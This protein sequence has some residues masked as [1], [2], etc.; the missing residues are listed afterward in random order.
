VSE[1]LEKYEIRVYDKSGTQKAYASSTA[2][3]PVVISAKFVLARIGGC[4]TAT[5]E[6]IAP[7]LPGTVV[8]GYL[9]EMWAKPVGGSLA[10][11]WRGEVVECPNAGNTADVLEYRAVG[12]MSQLSRK[13]ILQYYSN[14]DTDN[15]VTSLIGAEFTDDTDVDSGTGEV[16]IGTPYALG[17]AEFEFISGAEALKLLAD[18]QKLVDYGVD[19][20][21]KVYFKDQ[22]I[23]TVVERYWVGKHL[24]SYETADNMDGL[25][26][27]LLL[28]S[29]KVVGGG[30]LTIGTTDATSITSYG[31]RMKL[32]QIPHLR[33]ASDIFRM[34]EGKVASTKDP[35]TEVEADVLL[36]FADFHFP[37]GAV[38]V[39]DI[40]GNAVTLPIQKTIYTLD[41]NGF[42]GRFELGDEPVMSVDEEMQAIMQEV[43][44]GKQSQIS[45]TKIEHTRGQEWQQAALIDAREQGNYNSWFGTF[46]S[47]TFIDQDNS[48]NMSH[49]ASRGYVGCDHDHTDS[50]VQTFSIPLGPN[51]AT[52]AGTEIDSVR[53]HIDQD[54]HGRINFSGVNDIT[55]YFLGSTTSY[56][57]RDGYAQ[58]EAT[59]GNYMYYKNDGTVF[60]LPQEYNVKFGLKDMPAGGSCVMYVGY[61][62]ALNYIRVVATN[63]TATWGAGL[64]AN[65]AGAGDGLIASVTGL[66][67]DTDYQIE[68][69]IRNGATTDS[70]IEVYDYADVSKGSD[71][72]TIAAMALVSAGPLTFYSGAAVQAYLDYFEL[73]IY[74]N[75]LVV[76]LSRDGGTTWTDA[77]IN[78]GDTYKIVDIS[79]QPVGTGNLL[80][81]AAIKHPGRLYGWG[82][83]WQSA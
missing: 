49:D 74:S 23:T 50:T 25:V 34:A 39:T 56:I 70:E 7:G 76:S 51:P 63:G 5:I 47:T 33:D 36:S 73:P 10:R 21:G 29:K 18:A 28:Q 77:A 27:S 38:V 55:D 61:L 45:L 75:R 30:M 46:E 52:H 11:Y 1:L 35:R 44:V 12:L 80:M 40:D 62:S 41:S 81:K 72:G 16:S 43:G 48:H 3:E 71:T 57:I 6:A 26:N 83:S 9:L 65:V 22:D 15:I 42:R 60:A 2:G 31:E 66:T 14:D 32:E 4:T 54:W 79:A 58:C 53:L 67:K 64:Y 37:T 8:C 59:A 69:R 13:L 78:A 20:D 68:A 19:Q 82:A 24:A 17:D